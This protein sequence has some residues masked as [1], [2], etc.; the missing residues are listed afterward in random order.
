MF[1]KSIIR[2]FATQLTKKTPIT[3][4]YGDG[5]GPEIMT[6]TVDIV[7]AAGAQLE[8]ET[9]EI[10]EKVYARGITSGIEDKSWDSLLRTKVFLKA[11]LYFIKN[12]HPRVKSHFL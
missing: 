11:R 8:L 9:I 6:A 4:A 1:C 5:I 7:Q 10:G 12:F 2:S 3:I